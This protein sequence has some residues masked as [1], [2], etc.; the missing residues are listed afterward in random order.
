MISPE[1]LRQYPF[2]GHLND[3]Q[4]KSIAMIADEITFEKNVKLFEEGEDASVLYF[5][6]EGSVDLHYFGE[7]EMSQELK[8]GLPVGTINPGEPFAISAVIEPHIF[9]STAIATRPSRAI[10]IEAIPLLDLFGQDRR[11]AFLLTRQAARA[12]I[13]RLNSTRVQ[14]AAAL[15]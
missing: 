2:F 10:K 13:E 15:V 1:L 8:G 14:L 5:L 3:H 9:T 12:A 11:M 7:G 4:L 6:L